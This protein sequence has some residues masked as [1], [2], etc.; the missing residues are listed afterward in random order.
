MIV[1]YLSTGVYRTANENL[2]YRKTACLI[3]KLKK[4]GNCFNSNR[5]THS[6]IYNQNCY[7]LVN[8]R[9]WMA[10]SLFGGKWDLTIFLLW[11]SQSFIILFSLLRMLKNRCVSWAGPETN[12]S[13]DLC[14]D[15][16]KWRKKTIF[17]THT[18]QNKITVH[19][20]CRNV[21]RVSMRIKSNRSSSLHT[22]IIIS[23]LTIKHKLYERRRLVFISNKIHCI[24]TKNSTE[25][26]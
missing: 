1:W 21:T 11:K 14:I 6:P 26:R 2:I 19:G 15:I 22:F 18:M 20:I 5:Y 12:A 3:Y 9:F 8:N 7:L 4:S 24:P 17:G 23:K 25:C 10:F 13:C 16:K